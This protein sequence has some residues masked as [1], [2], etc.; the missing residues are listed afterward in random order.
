MLPAAPS[1]TLC[2]PLH[3]RALHGAPPPHHSLAPTCPQGE[4]QVQERAPLAN[5]RRHPVKQDDHQKLNGTH[6]DLLLLKCTRQTMSDGCSTTTSV[7]WAW[8]PASFS[9]SSLILVVATGFLLFCFCK[10]VLGLVHALQHGDV[11]TAAVGGGGTGSYFGAL[12]AGGEDFDFHSP[13]KDIPLQ[14]NDVHLPCSHWAEAGGRQVGWVGGWVGVEALPRA[15]QEGKQVY[16][17]INKCD[18][19]RIIPNHFS[20]Y[21]PP[22]QTK[23]TQYM[24]D[25]LSFWGRLR[26]KEDASLYACYDG[27]GGHLAAEFCSQQ[28]HHHLLAAWKEEEQEEE[29]EE[30]RHNGNSPLASSSSSSSPKA[31]L[32]E[33]FVTTDAALL[34]T[35]A[36]TERLDGTTALVSVVV[37]RKLYVA[38]AGDSRAILGR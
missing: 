32:K 9:P 10:A 21:P 22:T 6:F 8:L 14:P 11:G 1:P 23:H 3:T 13:P 33:C 25:R 5:S 15:C 36:G 28:L 17:W 4:P 35:L 24:E 19:G 26:N 31:A 30:R 16:E 29:G 20:T 12:G 34:E 37:G 27:H 18:S 7:L 38:N 2:L